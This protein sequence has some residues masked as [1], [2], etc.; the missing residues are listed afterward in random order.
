[1]FVICLVNILVLLVSKVSTSSKPSVIIIHYQRF[2]L[3]PVIIISLTISQIALTRC[4]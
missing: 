4:L 3:N 1:M 2:K